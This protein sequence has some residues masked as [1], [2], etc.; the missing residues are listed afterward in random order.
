MGY[1][2]NQPMFDRLSEIIEEA[3]AMMPIDKFKRHLKAIKHVGVSSHH[4]YGGF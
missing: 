1:E 4:N 3:N 2:I